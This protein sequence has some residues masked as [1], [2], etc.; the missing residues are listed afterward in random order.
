M[1]L[2]VA[3]AAALEAACAAGALSA[4]AFACEERKVTFLAGPKGLEGSTAVGACGVGIRAAGPGQG[5]MAYSSGLDRERCAAAGRGAWAARR[6]LEPPWRFPGPEAA[7]PVP[8]LADPMVSQFHPAQAQA[9]LAEAAQGVTAAGAQLTWVELSVLGRR[10]QVHNTLGVDQGVLATWV[11]VGAGAVAREGEQA[12]TANVRRVWRSLA[13]ACPL[14][15][16]QG[17]AALALSALGPKP[18]PTGRYPVV[19][20]PRA[21]ADLFLPGLVPA[22]LDGEVDAQPYREGEGL[23]PAWFNLFDDPLRAGGPASRAWDE[24]GE[25]ARRAELISRGTFQ[26]PLR[27]GG[28]AFR[29]RQGRLTTFIEAG[30]AYALGPVP[31]AT[32]LVVRAQGAPP[33]GNVDRALVVDGLLGAF[34]TDP[35]TGGFSV[36]AAHAWMMEQ[37]RLAH[38]VNRVM[39]SGR[40]RDVLS[41]LIAAGDD[42]DSVGYA[43]G[44]YLIT[45]SLCC[46]DVQVTG[47]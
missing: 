42:L 46:A 1:D 47:G 38:P 13:E 12:Y 28:H 23:G 41:G 45:P 26:G 14:E 31:G 21:L 10:F 27:L 2:K 8:G 39:L 29:R 34:V 16:G 18:V 35:A 17:A 40:V 3:T 6:R 20:R 36:T 9:L 15:V 25:P 33:L 24:T 43:P 7:Q 37:G 22:L 11:E 44:P 5:G 30:G 4:E 19:F 32:N